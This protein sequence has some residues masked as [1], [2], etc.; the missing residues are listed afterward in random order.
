M[1]HPTRPLDIAIVGGGIGGLTAALYL[2]RSGHDV[3]VYEQAAEIKAL[4]V[5]LNLFPHAVRRLYELG[6]EDGLS[7][8]GI[9]AS[10][11]AFYTQHGQEI[12]RDPAGLAA[13]YRWPHISIHRADLHEVLLRA[14]RAR[15]GDGRILTGHSCTGTTETD[16][17]VTLQLAELRSGISLPAVRADI[18]IGCDGIHSAIRRQFYPAEGKPVFGGINMWRGVTTGRPFLDGATVTRVGPIKTG[19]LVI[20]PIRNLE[21]GDQ[22]INWVAEI[23]RHVDTPNDWSMPGRLEDMLPAYEGWT[24]DWLDI[25]DLLRRSEILLEYPMVDRDPLP[26]W[27]FGRVTLLGDAAHPMYPRGGNGA[28]QS[29]L[30]AECLDAMLARHDD[31]AAAL[32]AYDGDRRPKTTG[33]VLANRVTPPDHIIEVTEERSGY[34][35]FDRLDDVIPKA[36]LDR[37][38]EDYK[39]T[40]AYD[41]AAVNEGRI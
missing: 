19:K 12:Y 29:I 26:R 25:P 7:K 13:G 16:D 14:V 27:S 36:E 41:L 38:I 1:H 30:D 3:R 8:V 2:H 9:R 28:A 31:P 6:L 11:F 33:V 24:F 15:L 40:A 23:R 10:A 22:L 4:G 21:G 32:A 18:A 34:K 17:G 20:Y 5:G 39:R 35:P 37:I